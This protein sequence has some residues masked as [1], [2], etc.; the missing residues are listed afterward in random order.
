GGARRGRTAGVSRLVE[1]QAR[2][3]SA[4]TS[5]ALALRACVRIVTNRLTPAVRPHTQAQ[6]A[7]DQPNAREERQH[8][9]TA[10][11]CR[12]RRQRFLRALDP[13]PAEGVVVLADPLHLTYLANFYVDP[14][15]SGAAYGGFLVLRPDGHATLI[16][17][18]R[19]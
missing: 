5:P 11:G 12:Q 6:P 19:L 9:L 17:G 3:A 16:H 2:S 13:F 14:V 8:M 10:E 4:G 15:S 18:G 1:T 7:R